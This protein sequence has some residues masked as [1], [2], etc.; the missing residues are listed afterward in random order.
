MIQ[1]F[2]SARKIIKK[3]QIRFY[4]T[5]NNDFTQLCPFDK[6]NMYFT[7]IYLVEIV[8]KKQQKGKIS[9]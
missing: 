8:K 9:N 4:I 3:K 6:R 2:G 5:L 1:V 7:Y